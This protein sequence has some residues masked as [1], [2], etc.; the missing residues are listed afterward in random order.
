VG[1]SEDFVMSPPG[2][3]DKVDA[4]EETNRMPLVRDI[5]WRGSTN[6]PADWRQAY[7]VLEDRE[8]EREENI[9]PLIFSM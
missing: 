6:R 7:F 9:K 8:S 4:A 5:R 3:S 2:V 1:I